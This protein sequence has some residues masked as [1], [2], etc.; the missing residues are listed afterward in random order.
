M[1]REGLQVEEWWW[2][3]D[4]GPV[5]EVFLNN[6][7]SSFLAKEDDEEDGGE[8]TLGVDWVEALLLLRLLGEENIVLY[9]RA[10][11]LIL[12]L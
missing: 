12:K 3:F 11:K 8:V 7:E 6:E 9:A 5:V 10:K 1:T 4:R 2:W